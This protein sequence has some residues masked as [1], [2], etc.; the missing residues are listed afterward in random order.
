MIDPTLR[1]L[2]QTPI[3]QA[4]ITVLARAMALRTM[5]EAEAPQRKMIDRLMRE[6]VPCYKPAPFRVPRVY[7]VKAAA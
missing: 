4:P 3:E 6:P 1:G 5:Y 7:A 2:L